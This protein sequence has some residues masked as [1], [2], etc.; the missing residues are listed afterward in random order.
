[1]V[2]LTPSSKSQAL[3]QSIEYWFGIFDQF[4]EDIRPII[5]FDQLLD[6]FR[7]K[8]S[9]PILMKDQNLL[10]HNDPVWV[11]RFLQQSNDRH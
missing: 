1:M 9:A 11:G 8:T 10:C 5:I 6:E 7:M 3:T 4:L 2:R